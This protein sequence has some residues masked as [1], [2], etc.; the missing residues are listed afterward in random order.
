MVESV[1]HVWFSTKGRKAALDG[2]IGTHVQRLLMQI[3]RGADIGLLEMEAAS[4]HVHLL[5]RPAVGQ[6]P[7]SVMHQLRVPA[8]AL[9]S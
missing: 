7:S 5:V 9:S 3:A 6:T 1:Y 4:D 2:E 8:P